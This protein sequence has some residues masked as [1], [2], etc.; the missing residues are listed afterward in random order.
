MQKTRQ[1]ILSFLIYNPGSS[2][3]DLARALEMTPANIRYHLN[4]LLDEGKIQT[5]GRRSA[6]GAGRPISLYN[7]SSKNLGDSLQPLLAA[8]LEVLSEQENEAF[9][10]RVGDMMVQTKAGQI[11]NRIQRFNQAVEYLN[12]LN[13]HANWEARPEGPRVELRHCPYKD[14]ALSHPRICLIDQR[15][16]SKLF[17]TPMVLIQ[18]R[19]FGNN[20]FSPC[21]FQN[22]TN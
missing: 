12:D 8:F 10:E 18:K 9:L 2:A 4:L 19:T 17:N 13:Y 21:V 14:L 1:N 22:P 20:P 11:P 6:G 3:A 16:I 15:I 7:L 5:S